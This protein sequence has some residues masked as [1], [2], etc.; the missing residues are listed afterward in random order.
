MSLV[1]LKKVCHVLI[2]DAED[3]ILLE[4]VYQ[5]LKGH[6]ETEKDILDELTATQKARMIESNNQIERGEVLSHQQVKA[7]F[8]EWFG[9]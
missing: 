2:E 4:N 9:R 3:D 7:Q 5:A 8:K 1:E 6:H